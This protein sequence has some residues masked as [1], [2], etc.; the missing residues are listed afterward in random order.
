MIDDQLKRSFDSTEKAL[1]A[2]EIAIAEPMLKSKL[3]IDGT[4]QRFEFS[5]ELFWKLLKR[6]LAAKGVDAPF[7]RDVLEK[8]Y[9]GHLI[10]DELVWLSMLRDRNQTSHTY[11]EELASEIYAR[12]KTYYPVFK[13]TLDVLKKEYYRIK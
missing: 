11:D 5:I 12:V 4:I 7:P 10:D 1:A 2:L 3:N 6:I 9:A 13:A 8:A